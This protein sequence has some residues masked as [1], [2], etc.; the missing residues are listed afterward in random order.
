MSTDKKDFFI[1]GIGASAGGLDA[2]QQLFDNI[3][4]NTGMAFVVVQHLSPDFKS[5]MPELLAKHT[6]MSIFTAEDNQIIQQN[7]IYL[8]KEDKNLT[9]EEGKLHLVDR[10]S[11]NKLNLPINEFFDS[12]GGE[13]KEKSIGIVLSG[14]GSDGSKGIKTIKEAGGCLS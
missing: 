13:Y 6:T 3:P 10:G 9:V 7:C 2:I 1:A 14:T 5:L 4:N 11:K 12:L 8:N